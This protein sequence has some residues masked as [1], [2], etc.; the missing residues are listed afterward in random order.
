MRYL[1]AICLFAVFGLATVTANAQGDGNPGYMSTGA[2][3]TASGLMIN[4]EEFETQRPQISVG[5]AF[6]KGER[7]MVLNTT[8]TQIRVPLFGEYTGGYFDFNIPI[9]SA[10]GELGN[11]WGLDDVTA[12]YTHM[13][14]GLEDWL[15]QGTLGL[16]IGMSTANQTDGK[17]RPLPMAYQPGR[18]SLDVIAGASITWKKYLTAAVGYQQPFYRYNEND[19]FAAHDLNDTLYSAFN[20]TVARKLYRQG[21][22]ML[23]LEGH[24]Y[25]NRWGIT[26]GAVGN[27]HL[28]NDLYQDRNTGLWHEI[29]GT[30][31]LTINLTG[32]IFMRFGRYGEYKI[33]LTGSTPLKRTETFSAGLAREWFLM[34]RFTFYFNSKQSLLMF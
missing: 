27:Y 11:S 16:N 30:E 23:R 8:H 12:T 33:D 14:T 25:N 10:K 17:A 4:D 32:N 2:M 5:H 20:Y 15:V 19:F 1:S 22:V 9:F 3:R 13:F 18:G 24:Y 31:G 29:D 7:D 21:D 6:A 28:A 26:G 34:P